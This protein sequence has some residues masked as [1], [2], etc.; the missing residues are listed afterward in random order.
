[1]AGLFQSLGHNLSQ[2][3]CASLTDPTDQDAF[4]GDL[5]LGALAFN[6]GDFAMQTLLPQAG[7]PLIDA[8]DPTACWATDQR[9]GSRVGSVRLWARWSMG[10]SV[11]RVYLPMVVRP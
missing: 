5:L 1:M 9:G 6:G 7:S 8:G 3:S 11:M 4:P 2:G 10:R